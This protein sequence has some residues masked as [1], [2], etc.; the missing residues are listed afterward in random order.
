MGQIKVIHT[1]DWHL[2]KR[3]YRKEREAEHALFLKWLEGVLEV[4]K[5]DAL[6]LAGD[7][8]D[9]PTPPHSSLKLYYDFLKR[10]SDLGVHTVIISG[11]HDSQGLIN[12]PQN[13]L[14][15]KKIHLYSKLQTELSKNICELSINGEKLFIKCLP[16]FR[17]FE[18]IKLAQTMDM[19]QE[20][21]PR[22]EV[23][24]AAL[25]SFLAYWPEKTKGNKMLLAHHVF[26]EYAATGSEHF[27]SLS[28]I[29]SIALSWLNGHFDYTALGHIH[30]FQS[31]SKDQNAYY[32]GSPLQ[33]RFSESKNKYIQKIVFDSDGEAPKLEKVKIPVF[34]ELIP[35][36][37][38]SN[39]YIEDIKKALSQTQGQLE[40]FVEVQIEMLETKTGL[41]DLVKDMCEE[42][43]ASLLSFL[44][45]LKEQGQI[46]EEKNALASELNIVELFKRF[47]QEKFPDSEQVPAYL[48]TRFRELLDESSHE[49]S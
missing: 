18:L 39:T 35:I 1:S 44:P 46:E 15:D 5:V 12:A 36:K 49:D 20:D 26:G 8:F 22:E 45:V 23:F 37:T 24:K 32:T 30:Q 2:G 27:I 31:L 11:N 13:I 40:P 29:D 17:N 33:M 16:Y 25:K 42:R 9:S 4:E 38:N 48:E 7:V 19:F 34:R 3:L 10:A 14:K 47:Y 41:V 28:G 43:G 21:Q 6:V